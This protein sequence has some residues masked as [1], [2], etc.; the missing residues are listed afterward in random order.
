VLNPQDELPSAVEVRRE[1]LV[2]ADRFRENFTPEV[3]GGQYV[4]WMVDGFSMGRGNW[5]AVSVAG[6]EAFYFWRVLD[7]VDNTSETITAALATVVN[8]LHHNGFIV[9]AA[10]TDNA[11]NEIRAVNDLPG[12][13]SYPLVRIPC[14]SHTLNL[15]VHDFFTDVFGKDVFETDLQA[16]Y[17]VL[18]KRSHGDH[19]RGWSSPC[20]TR[21]LS[22]GALV[23]RIV[24]E[25]SHALSLFDDSSLISQR[26]RSYN[27]PEL[28]ACFRVVNGL[29]TWTEGQHSFLDAV[30]FAALEALG[31]L[32]ALYSH[33]NIPAIH[34]QKAVS[35][36]LFKTADYGQL[37]L[38][39]LI[40]EQGLAWYRGLPLIAPPNCFSCSYVWSLIND[41]LCFFVNL[42]D[43]NSERFMQAFRGYLSKAKWPAHQPMVEF[44]NKLS[45]YPRTCFSE[46]PASYQLIAKMALILMRMPCSEAEVER[47]FSRMR[48]IIGKRSIRIKRDLL[49]SRLIL[50]M[51][52]SNMTSDRL[53]VLDS[54]EKQDDTSPDEG[55]MTPPVAWGSARPEFP[56][57]L[58]FNPRGPRQSDDSDVLFAPVLL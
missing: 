41:F 4:C 6:G 30:W 46:E 45:T 9:C 57:P 49:E 37:L 19:F 53:A 18:R 54:L 10:V 24:A 50:E 3:A 11:A 58:I 7:L 36:R 39:Y 5:L 48:G 15:A 27:F 56:I 35:D 44:W 34:F 40:T 25:Y 47:V 33:G 38:G 31:K 8:E 14:M 43:A 22:F 16:F 52:G 21:W 13:T 29:M 23:E 32:A 20:R 26:F 2:Q 28:D 17:D 55:H 51:N 42:F 12:A 1:I